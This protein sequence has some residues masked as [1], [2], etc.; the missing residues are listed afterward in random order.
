MTWLATSVLNRLLLSRSI[1][2]TTQRF[3]FIE[4]I[5]IIQ[6]DWVSVMSKRHNTR[7]GWAIQ[8][9]PKKGDKIVNQWPFYYGPFINWYKNTSTIATVTQIEPGCSTY[10]TQLDQGSVPWTSCPPRLVHTLWPLTWAVIK[11]PLQ[12]RVCGQLHFLLTYN[13]LCTTSRLPKAFPF[14]LDSDRAQGKQ[15][16]W[17]GLS[18]EG[19]KIVLLL[20]L[21]FFF[22]L[23]FGGVSPA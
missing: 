6:T 15:L 3:N 17:P 9:E 22:F 20:L 18:R 14:F 5:N 16:T 8:R 19:G 2:D 10:D 12:H 21:F 11:D 1:Q 23:F 4:F 7:F 13:Q